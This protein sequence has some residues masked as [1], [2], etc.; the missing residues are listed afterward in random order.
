MT[1]QPSKRARPSPTIRVGVLGLLAA[2]LLVLP[3]ALAPRADA[4]VYWANDAG[5]A[6]SA[7][8]T[9]TAPGSTRASSPSTTPRRAWRSTPSTSTGRTVPERDRPR[10]PRWHRA[11]T[12]SF[13]PAATT[14]RGEAGGRRRPHLLVLLDLAA[15]NSGAPARSAA[16]TSTAPASTRASSTASTPGVA[17][18]ASPRLLDGRRRLPA[19]HPRTIGRANLDGTGVEPISS[20]APSRPP[21]VLAVD[22][23]HIYWANSRRARSGAPTSTAPAS[24][25]LH[26]R[27]QASARGRRHQSLEPSTAPTSTGRTPVRRDRPRQPRRHRRRPGLHRLRLRTPLASRSTASPTPSSRA[28]RAPRR[29]S[30]KGQEDRRQ[31]QGQ[32]QGATDRQ[33]QRQD[34]GKSHLQAEAEGGPGSGGQDQ[35]AEAEAEEGQGEEDRQGAEARREGDGEGQGKAHRPGRKP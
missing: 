3:L 8:P 17:V 18:D 25:G 11:S 32:G 26:L 15:T 29:P 23:G 20:P 34:Q 6:R 22:S 33:G 13:I 35:D 27:R 2:I 14:R 4:F 24:T 5:L 31:G 21:G 9:S 12:P 28:R 1:Q 7:A 19:R 10:E 30:D 16:P